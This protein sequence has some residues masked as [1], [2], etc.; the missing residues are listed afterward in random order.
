MAK[1][2]I[3]FNNK[4]YNIEIPSEALAALK[5][6]LSTVMNGTGATIKLD[7][8]SY[9]VDSTKLSAA[10]NEFVAHLGTISGEG[11]KVKVGGVEYGVD[12]AKVAEAVAAF[13][14]V[15]GELNGGNGGSV[16]LAETELNFT[17]EPQYIITEPLE[18]IAGKSYTVNWKDEVYECVAFEIDGVVYIGDVDTAMAEGLPK[19]PPF[20]FQMFPP[21][22][23][24]EMGAY[25]IVMN[26]NTPE[27]VKCSII[28]HTT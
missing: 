26:D 3:S 9:G 28:E 6:H 13:E 12:S 15:L 2:N 17:A 18:L 23:V 19:N 25:A 7:G 11:E 8:Q 5:S 4:K 16:I 27:I 21:E 22:L 10:T 1:I 20:F 14:G 24:A